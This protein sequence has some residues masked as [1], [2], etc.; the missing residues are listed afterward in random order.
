MTH[1]F[2]PKGMCHKVRAVAIVETV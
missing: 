1:A 2:S